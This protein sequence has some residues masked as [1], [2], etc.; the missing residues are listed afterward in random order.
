MLKAIAMVLAF[1]TIGETVA[2]FLEVPLPGAAIAL[3]L[4]LLLFLRQGG[5]DK[6]VARLFDSVS[7]IIPLFFVPA[8][9]GVVANAGALSHAWIHVAAAIVIGTTATIAVTGLIAHGLLRSIRQIR[10]S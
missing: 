8:A 4:L 7:P 5:P 10:T 2:E 3:S 6:H 9:V 1:S